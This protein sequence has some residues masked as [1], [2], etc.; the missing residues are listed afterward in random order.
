MF[1]YRRKHIKTILLSSLLITILLAGIIPVQAA[2]VIPGADDKTMPN[3]KISFSDVASESPLYPSVRYMAEK[4]IFKGFP[5]GSF[6]PAEN[7]TRAQTAKILAVVKGLPEIKAKTPAFSDV[8]A[9]YWAFGAIEAAAKNGLLKGYPGGTFKPEGILTRAEAVTLL[10]NLSGGA[11]SDEK[12]TIGDVNQNHWAYRQVVTAVDA[13]LVTLSPDKLFNPDREFRRGDMARSLGF[14]YTV[15]PALRNTALSGKLVVKKGEAIITGSSGIANKVTGETRVQ[16]GVKINTG[17]N[18]QAEITFDDGSGIQLEANT[19]IRID[20][21]IG[22]NYMRKDGSSGVAVDQL[23]ISLKKGRIFGALASKYD[24]E[25]QPGSNQKKTGRIIENFRKLTAL[26]DGG[27]MLLAAN[28]QSPPWYKTAETKKVRVKVDMPWGVA[29]IRGTF[30]GNFVSPSGESSTSV[31]IGNA[32][33]ISGGQ[34][35]PVS[36]GQSTVV[37]ASGAPPA[38]P[39]AFSQAEQ[40]AWAVVANWV[41][42]RAQEIQNNLPPSLAPAIQSP[43][44]PVDQPV[45]PVQQNN[46]NQPQQA[47][48]VNVVHVVVQSLSQATGVPVATLMNSVPNTPVVTPPAVTAPAGGGGGGGAASYQ[49]NTMTI[50]TSTVTG[51]IFSLPVVLYNAADIYA[52]SFKI[53]FNN[54][55]LQA[56][57]VQANTSAFPLVIANDADNSAG[58]VRLI[59]SKQGSTAGA[60]GNVQA[61]TITFRVI[62]NG[63]SNLTFLEGSLCNSTPSTLTPVLINTS[64]NVSASVTGGSGTNR[65]WLDTSG[66]SGSQ[67]SIPVKAS[68]T[69]DLYGADVTISFDKNKLE[70]LSVAAN[71]SQFPIVAVSSADNANGTVTLVLTRQGNSAGLSGEVTLGS[72]SFRVLSPGTSLLSFAN[73]RL[74]D[75]Q[76]NYT[77]VNAVNSS[78]TF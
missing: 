30:W 51:S 76:L 77:S 53:S 37:A 12:M 10:M 48:T 18:S 38:A 72:I 1:V 6:R 47:T 69:S 14:M 17:D 39:A 71:T 22:F 68:Y 58:T 64:V 19:E 59:A 32:E 28:D 66:V 46:V 4:G 78:I 3:H 2:S 34:T 55:Y 49:A 27:L 25:T 74:C 42:E 36:T 16:A 75:S 50:D 7:I 67:F 8:P 41:I 57:S 63:M 54:Q 24:A 21:A 13:G 11:L 70:A 73:A 20:K 43:E 26:K 56:V 60:S 23:E 35:V 62:G 9:D 52:V 15:S 61:G 5:D 45:T 65:I 40:Q 44:I 31:I 33:V 29:A